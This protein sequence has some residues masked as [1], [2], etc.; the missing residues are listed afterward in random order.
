LDHDLVLMGGG[1]GDAGLAVHPSLGTYY[2]VAMQT[3]APALVRFLDM[4][5]E[6][7]GHDL[8]AEADP[9]QL[10]VLGAT[11]ELLQRLD[12]RQRVVDAGR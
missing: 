9:D 3:R 11:D 6:R 10:A 7:L 1:F 8:V 4:T 2:I 12:P 5:A